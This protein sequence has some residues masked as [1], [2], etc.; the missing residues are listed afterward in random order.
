MSEEAVGEEG[1]RWNRVKKPL[2][3]VMR[4]VF[5]QNRSEPSKGISE[6]LG[7]VVLELGHCDL[8]SFWSRRAV[9]SPFCLSQSLR[10]TPSVWKV[11]DHGF[12][13]VVP[14]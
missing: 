9:L 8:Q 7:S 4:D 1:Q 12:L 3:V 13:V 14:A 11:C 2:H 10:R 6:Y 5:L